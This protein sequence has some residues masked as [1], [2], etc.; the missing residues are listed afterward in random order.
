M[1]TALIIEDDLDWDIRIKD[2]LSNFAMA[3][4]VLIQPQS[5]DQEQRLYFN[6]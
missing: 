1:N 2:Q 6:L 4:R 3:S 5:L